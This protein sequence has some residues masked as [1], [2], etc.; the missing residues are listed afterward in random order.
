MNSEA[1]EKI[2]EGMIMITEGL[3]LFLH[4]DCNDAENVK[5]NCATQIELSQIREILSEKASEGKSE[6]VKELI[7]LF[8]A[9]RLS[10]I[11]YEYYEELLKMAERL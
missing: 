4:K 3:K 6:Q 1:L 11:S 2:I 10:D 8:K 7:K 9:E 5:L